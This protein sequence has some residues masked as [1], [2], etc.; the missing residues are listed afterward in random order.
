MLDTTGPEIPN[1]YRQAATLEPS[2][3]E[4]SRVLRE[5]AARTAKHRMRRRRGV[6]VLAL[7]VVVAI[8]AAFAYPQT[9]DA[10]DNFFAGGATPGTQVDPGTLPAWLENASNLPAAHPQKGSESLLAEQ[11]GQRL[12]A[13]RDAT[14][15]RACVVFASDSDTCSSDDEWHQL[16]GQH[17]VLKLASG[18]GPTE[19]GKVAVFGLARSSVVRVELLDGHTV[20]AEAPVTNGGWV[21]VAD[22]GSHGSLVGL[23]SNG[24]TVETLD[25]SSWTW[26]FCTDEAGCP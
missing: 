15:G 13:Y 24:N 7:A 8:T 10:L 12:F 6:A 1:F 20:A 19:D 11:D 16:F 25:A 14:T 5:L 2:E 17:A 21:I 22:Q 18:V 23:D 9:L 3:V 26:S 4:V